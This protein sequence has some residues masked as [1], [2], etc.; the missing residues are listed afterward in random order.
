MKICIKFQIISK[1]SYVNIRRYD[2]TQSFT[3]FEIWT[4]ES[5]SGIAFKKIVERVVFG[6]TSVIK[7]FILFSLIP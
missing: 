1:S 2:V 4:G 7:I 3:Q 5:L 6:E